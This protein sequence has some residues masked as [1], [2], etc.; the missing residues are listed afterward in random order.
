VGLAAQFVQSPSVLASASFGQPILGAA[1]SQPMRSSALP[2]GNLPP[3]MVTSASGFSSF[4]CSVHARKQSSSA[5]LQICVKPIAMERLPRDWELMMDVVERSW[6]VGVGST[7][8]LKKLQQGQPERRELDKRKHFGR[9]L[10]P[11]SP[12]AEQLPRLRAEP[13]GEQ[14]AVTSSAWSA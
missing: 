7:I 3:S 2:A 12:S 1:R 14:H 10:L 11:C 5:A 4:T 8:A 6:E 9:H 13:V